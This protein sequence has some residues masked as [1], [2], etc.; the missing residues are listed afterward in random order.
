MGVQFSQKATEVS[1]RY[2]EKVHTLGIY[3]IRLTRQ[4]SSLRTPDT[5]NSIAVLT[6]KKPQGPAKVLILLPAQRPVILTLELASVQTNQ[7][8]F[9]KATFPEKSLI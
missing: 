1:A 8:K 4:T 5:R 3:V 2:L 9:E 6:T 7:I